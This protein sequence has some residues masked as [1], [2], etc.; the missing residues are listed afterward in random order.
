MANQKIVESIKKARDTKKRNF[1]QA[2]DLAINL[3]NMDMKKPENKIK[4][5]VNVPNLINE[6]VKIGLIVD[7]LALKT[8]GLE[9]VRVI[10]KD[11]LESLSNNKKMA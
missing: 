4:V 3:K 8:E 2:F 7:V 9:N 5:E 11:E 1:K 6:N 10:K